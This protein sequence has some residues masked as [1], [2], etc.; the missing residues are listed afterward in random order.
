MP[1]DDH[2]AMSQAEVAAVLGCSRQLVAYIEE[3]ALAK[4]RRLLII[5]RE[6]EATA[7]RPLDGEANRKL[8]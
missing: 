1:D 7:L 6:A 3:R 2:Y 5:E 8:G 4:L